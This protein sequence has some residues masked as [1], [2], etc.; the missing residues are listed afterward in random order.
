MPYIWAMKNFARVLHFVKGYQ[1]YVWL[2]VLANVL[3][4]I[5]NLISTILFVPL[6]QLLFTNNT[7]ADFQKY[8]LP[9]PNDVGSIKY[10]EFELQS[11]ISEMIL[12]P[13]NIVDGKSRVLILFAAVIVLAFL[14]KNLFRYFAMFFLL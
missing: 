7:A 3:Y 11:W 12:E 14:L 10:Y 13:N 4:S 6:L 1:K 5:F 2:T 9:N 8:L